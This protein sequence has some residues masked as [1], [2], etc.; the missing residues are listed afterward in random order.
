MR[1][2]TLPQHIVGDDLRVQGIAHLG[3]AARKYK[4]KWWLFTDIKYGELAARFNAHVRSKPWPPDDSDE[5]EARWL[6][7]KRNHY[8]AL[9]KRQQELLDSWLGEGRKLGEHRRQG[10]LEAYRRLIDGFWAAIGEKQPVEA[11]K[12]A[13]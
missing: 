13:P 12:E 7:D 6:A 8:T 9:N 4:G 11:G 3:C 1:E 5:S 10:I 2:S